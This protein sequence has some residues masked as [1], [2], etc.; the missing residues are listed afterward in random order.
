MDEEECSGPNCVGGNIVK[1]E[2]V[3]EVNEEGLCGGTGGFGRSRISGDRVMG[4]GG[5]CRWDLSFG[6]LVLVPPES[7]WETERGRG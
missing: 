5:V 1:G 3:R 6:L 4:G 7:D 2:D